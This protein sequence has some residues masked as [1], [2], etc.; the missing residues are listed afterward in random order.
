LL[1][2]LEGPENSKYEHLAGC[3]HHNIGIVQMCQGDF[4]QALESFQKA[5]QVRTECLPQNH[6]DIAVSLVRQGTAYFALENF[7]KAIDSFR[8]A[9]HMS[10]TEDAT[11][12]KV[13]N[14]LGLA[15]YLQDNHKKA[16]KALTGALEI[17]RQWLDSPVRREPIV[18][19]ASVTLGNMGKIY[20]KK[21][22]FDLAYFVYEE[23]CL[24]RPCFCDSVFPCLMLAHRLT[25]LLLLRTLTQL[26]TTSFRKDHAIVLVSLGNMALAK[27]K[28]EDYRKAS[29]IFSSIL[30]SQEAKFG[31]QSRHTIETIGMIGF[32]RMKELKLDDALKRLKTVKD[33]QERNLPSSHPAKSM[34]KATIQ[35]VEEVLARQEAMWI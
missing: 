14:N 23:A 11:R 25:T 34:T 20:L 26:Q 3:T 9:L 8:T 18:Y 12:A 4:D 29:Q 28:G 17:Q 2:G 30:R 7:E 10:P 24:V 6:P 5:V 27:A 15:Y 19:D 16:L 31:A 1:Q 21:A 13:L 33:W 22:D 35:A 32:I